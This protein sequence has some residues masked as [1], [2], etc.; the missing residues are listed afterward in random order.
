MLRLEVVRSCDGHVATRFWPFVYEIDNEMKQD[1]G[2]LC[3][4]LTM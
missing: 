3:V 1:C 4:N 2:H